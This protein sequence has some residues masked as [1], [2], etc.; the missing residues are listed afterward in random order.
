MNRPLRNVTPPFPFFP[1]LR[2]GKLRAPQTANFAILSAEHTSRPPSTTPQIHPEK[3]LSFPEPPGG[4]RQGAGAGPAAP[5][6]PETS[7]ALAMAAG[8]PA[9]PA[10][11]VTSKRLSIDVPPPPP[12]RARSALRS[13]ELSASLVEHMSFPSGLQAPVTTNR[14]A[15]ACSGARRSAP[16]SPSFP[17]SM[18]AK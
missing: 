7:H 16:P 11:Y 9:L 6:G 17:R 1:P 5:S 10:P 14:A 2:A 18:C 12:E 13:A 4:G 8:M 15:P 3:H